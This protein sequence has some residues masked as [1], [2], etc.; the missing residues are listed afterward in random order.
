MI[1]S[2][3]SKPLAD[4]WA[5][6]SSPKIDSRMHNRIIRRLEALE[7]AMVPE[8]MNVPGFNFHAPRGLLPTRYTVHIDGPSCITFSFDGEDAIAVDFEQYH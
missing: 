6:G 3:R 2:F 8:D 4:L 7:A 1:R 5:K